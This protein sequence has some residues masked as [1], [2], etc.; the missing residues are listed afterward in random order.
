MSST[1]WPWRMLSC[2]AILH[3]ASA[4][5]APAKRQMLREQS[6]A[7]LVQRPIPTA[8]HN[9][10]LSAKSGNLTSI[11]TVV[12]TTLYTQL[13][14]GSMQWVNALA[15]AAFGF[16]MVFEGETS[17]NL[18]IVAVVYV[19][20]WLLGRAEIQHSWGV[21][22]DSLVPNIVGIGIG[23]VAAFSAWKG[24]AG[25]LIMLGAITGLWMAIQVDVF[26]IRHL[27]PIMAEHVT[28]LIFY[29]AAS[30]AGAYSV[31]CKKYLQGVA[32]LSPIVGGAFAS[33]SLCW[34]GA[35][36]A[37]NGYLSSIFSGITP[38]NGAWI[39]FLVMLWSTHPSEVGIFPGASN[40]VKIRSVSMT[41]DQIFGKSLWIILAL[42]GVPFQL[43]QHRKMQ[44]KQTAKVQ[45]R[46]IDF[47]STKEG[48]KESLLQLVQ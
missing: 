21:E 47:N 12:E 18:I 26:L 9:T 28:Q 16:F 1:L 30:Y 19:L 11:V 27:F 42:I 40:A 41:P 17:F 29:T 45:A 38:K 24:V 4:S 20:T 32:V 36:L 43:R 37:S 39:D 44:Q 48:L 3:L 15:S 35:T 6:E 31:H 33:S 2:L 34:L 8:I 22:P 5:S 14:Y 46:E 10:A 25:V 7:P 13:A 23:L